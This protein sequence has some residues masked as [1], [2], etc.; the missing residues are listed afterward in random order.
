VKLSQRLKQYGKSFKR[1][2][3]VYRAVAAH[4]QTPR[5]AK[6]L[7]GLALAYAL[8]PFD[9]IPDWIPVLGL[10]DDLIILP[11]LVWLAL[12]SVPH[13][14]YEECRERVGREELESGVWEHESQDG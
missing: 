12:R 14:V 5:R 1:Q 6:W 9:L 10:L 11:L 4:P 13:E 7:L 8:M 3:A 2:V